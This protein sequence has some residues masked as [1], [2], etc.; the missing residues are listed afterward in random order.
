MTSFIT[1]N[2]TTA[3]PKTVELLPAAT[4][5]KQPLPAAALQ[6][7]VSMHSA[8]IRCHNSGSRC[9]D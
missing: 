8:K 1:I 7:S 9:A 4:A 3:S 6:R 5:R 2:S